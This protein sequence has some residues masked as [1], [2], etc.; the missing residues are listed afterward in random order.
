MIHASNIGETSI[1]KPTAHHSITEEKDTKYHERIYI[2]SWDNTKLVG[3]LI[4]PAKIPEDKKLPAVIF[5]NSWT[6]GEHEYYMQAKELAKKGYLVLSYAA[7]GWWLSGGEITVAGPEDI[8][9]VSAAIDWLVARTPVDQDKIAV[10]GMSYGAGIGLLSIAHDER[11]ATVI[12]FCAWGTVKDTLWRNQSLHKNWSKILFESSKYLGTPSQTLI[13]NFER[14][15]NHEEIP[16]LLEWAAARSPDT[17]IEEINKRGVPIYISNNLGDSLFDSNDIIA[18]FN[19][20]TVP[21]KLDLNQGNHITAQ[22]GG[23]LGLNNYSWSQAYKWLDHWLK[24][25]QTDIMDRSPI[26]MESRNDKIRIELNSLPRKNGLN[27]LWYLRPGPKKG[28]GALIGNVNKDDESRSLVHIGKSSRATSGSILANIM[29]SHYKKPIKVDFDRLSRRKALVYHSEVLPEETF[30]RGAPIVELGL[31]S[32]KDVG[33]LMIYLY[34]TD[35]DDNI[36]KLIASA[37][38]TAY[39]LKRKEIRQAK[40]QL[41]NVAYKVPKNHHLTLVIDTVDKYYQLPQKGLWQVTIHSLSS[42]PASISIPY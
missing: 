21:K 4:T 34:D 23:L 5:I 40:I 15:V 29:Q 6:M 10:I 13:D 39:D 16:I 12:G 8:R 28:D 18:F 24:S 37:P 7:R 20:L 42:N 35:P 27:K 1:N 25:K 17:Y 41:T 14:L 36:G 33:Q 26:T 11:V 22:S 38:Y 9:D 30:I 19:K 32:T 3:N 31:S 2:H